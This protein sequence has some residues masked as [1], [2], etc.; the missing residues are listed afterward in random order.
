MCELFCLSSGQPAT[1]SFSLERLARH[2]A[3]GQ[4][5]VDGWGLAFYDDRDVRLYKEPEPA[6]E[7]AWLSYILGRDMQTGL[8]I[9]HIRRASQGGLTHANTQPFTRELAGRMHVFAH[10]GDLRGLPGLEPNALEVFTPVGQTDS[11]LAFC[12]LLENLAPLWLR[13]GPPSADDRLA[14]VRTFADEMRGRGEANFLYSDGE[15]LFAHAHRAG[16]STASTTSPAFGGS[17]TRRPWPPTPWPTT[18]SRSALRRRPGRSLW[19]PA[20][21]SRTMRGNPSTRARSWFSSPAGWRSVIDVHDD[22]APH[23]APQ[24]RFAEGRD[25]GERR[26]A[27]H[28][29]QLGQVEILGQAGPGLNAAG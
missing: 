28:G 9:S 6:G 21:L 25:L 17:T 15:L 4:A 24:D 13:G 22:P 11:E 20:F 12:L 19:W 23:L 26:V 14:V 18:A 2:G 7:S 5:N 8:A 29:V 27:G 10:N 16:R 1:V 3:L